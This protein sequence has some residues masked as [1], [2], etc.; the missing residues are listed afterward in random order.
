MRIYVGEC[1]RS[2]MCCADRGFLAGCGNILLFSAAL[3]E[4]VRFSLEVYVLCMCM[5]GMYFLI[6][7]LLVVVVFKSQVVYLLVPWRLSLRSCLKPVFPP[8]CAR[9]QHWKCQASSEH[10]MTLPRWGTH[11]PSL[12]PD[13][14]TQVRSFMTWWRSF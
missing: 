9:Q 8:Q 3:F 13:A 5:C 4:S 14:F 6:D 12:L 10:K 1:C 11:G 7:V 2:C